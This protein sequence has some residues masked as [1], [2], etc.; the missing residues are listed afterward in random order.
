MSVVDRVLDGVAAVA[1]A[2][3]VLLIAC[4]TIGGFCGG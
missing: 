3:G 2:M 4:H 1:V